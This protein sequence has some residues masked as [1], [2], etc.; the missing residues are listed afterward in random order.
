MD[1]KCTLLQC[2]MIRVEVSMV[3]VRWLCGWWVDLVETERGTVELVL[4]WPLALVD[5]SA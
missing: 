1:E 4:G 3:M 2:P 5:S